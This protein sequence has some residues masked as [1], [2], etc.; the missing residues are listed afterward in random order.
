MKKRYILSALGVGAASY[1][2]TNPSSR[3][4]LKDMIQGMT[5][6]NN[7]DNPSV[8]ENAGEP[9]Q[10]TNQE[11]LAQLENAKMV[12]EGSQFGVQYFNKV[13]NDGFKTE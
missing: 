12:S 3:D 1:L 13:K 10:F 8:M 6:D 11:D 5:T 7:L 9:D 2:L 4:K